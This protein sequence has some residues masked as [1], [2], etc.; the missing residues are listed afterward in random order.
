MRHSI[1][2]EGSDNMNHRVDVT[3]GI[4]R[5]IPPLSANESLDIDE[6]DR[7]VGG[8]LRLKDGSEEIDAFVGH[9]N[10]TDVRLGLPSAVGNRARPGLGQDSEDRGLAD[11]REPDDARF[12]VAVS[13]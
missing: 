4:Q 7:C 6:F 11:L 10:D 12:H 5:H 3:N 13:G 1:V 8:L 2:F 9:L